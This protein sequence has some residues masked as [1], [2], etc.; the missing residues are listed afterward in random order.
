MIMTSEVAKYHCVI[1]LQRQV[2][3]EIKIL[4]WVKITTNIKKEM[5]KWDEHS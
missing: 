1:F 4:P 5:L 3:H 2:K